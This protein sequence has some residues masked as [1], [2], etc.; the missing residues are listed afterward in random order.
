MRLYETLI[1]DGFEARVVS[2]APKRA[3]RDIPTL[4][5]YFP[6]TSYDETD[7]ASLILE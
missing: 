6:H 7:L 3:A 5:S 2:G 1:E 4:W